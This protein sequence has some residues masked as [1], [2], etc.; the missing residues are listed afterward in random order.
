VFR[1]IK[2]MGVDDIII[3]GSNNSS[4]TIKTDLINTEINLNDYGISKDFGGN[5]NSLNLKEL[6]PD[7]IGVDFNAS[8]SLILG[9]TIGVNIL[10]HTRGEKGSDKYYPEIHIYTGTRI[11]TTIKAEASIGVFVAWARNENGGQAE[12]SWVANGLNWTGNFDSESFSLGNLTASH[13]SSKNYSP[14]N[15]WE[16][17]QFSYSPAKFKFGAEGTG[18]KAIKS[19]LDEPKMFGKIFSGD[20]STTS[21]YMI[22]G[23]GSD[24]LSNG[25][26]ISGWHIWNPID[27][28]DNE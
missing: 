20:V 6:T 15:Y 17:V 11:G 26:N 10:W 3:R 18:M 8:A 21:Y 28:T 13:F 12:S 19:V 2:G 7:A 5:D 27:P 25:T 22:Y 1:D 4:F 9:A 14:T 24:Y 23:N 16:G